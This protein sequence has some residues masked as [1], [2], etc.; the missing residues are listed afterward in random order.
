M[1]FDE[2]AGSEKLDT[3]VPKWCP[4]SETP[5]ELK[6]SD[7]GKWQP[8]NY[9]DFKTQK[10]TGCINTCLCCWMM[11][12]EL[13]RSQKVPLFPCRKFQLGKALNSGKI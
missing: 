13:R 3:M 6:E 7:I 4:N 8:A 1:T 2:L 10:M 5:E 11:L 12:E 9:I